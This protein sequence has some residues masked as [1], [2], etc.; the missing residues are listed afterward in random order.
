MSNFVPK[1]NSGTLWPNDRKN[2]P[3]HPDMRGDIYLDP[4]FLQDM[5]DKSA[6]ELVKIQISAWDKVL[7]GKNCLSVSASAPYVKPEGQASSAG[8]Q[9]G[10]AKPAAP[11]Q[12]QI[13]DEDIPF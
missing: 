6:G 1:P 12:R 11:P 10:G 9:R 8:Y 13:D 4:T 7:A 5:I 3:N 2:A